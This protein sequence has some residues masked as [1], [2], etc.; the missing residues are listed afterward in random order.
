MKETESELGK[1]I[2]WEWEELEAKKE[3]CG[4]RAMEIGMSN[5]DSI[6]G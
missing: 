4:Y 3:K 2:R 6:E 5:V 1:C